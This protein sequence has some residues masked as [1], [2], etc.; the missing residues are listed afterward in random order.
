MDLYVNFHIVNVCD[1]PFN[2]STMCSGDFF[3]CILHSLS[4]VCIRVTSEHVYIGHLWTK[5]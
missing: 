3:V 5:F 1:I 2:N 4:K